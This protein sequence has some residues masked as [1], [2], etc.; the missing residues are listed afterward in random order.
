MKLKTISGHYGQSYNL[1]HNNRIFIPNNVDIN[2]V[3][4][5][6]YCI[7][8]GQAAEID[9]EQP[10]DLREFWTR[11]RELADIYWSDRS[12]QQTLAYEKYREQQKYMR[13]YYRAFY[14][15]PWNPISAMIVLLMLPLLIP[16]GLYLHRQQALARDELEA[17]QQDQMI[18]DLAFK[19]S[20]VSLRRALYEQDLSAGTRY[21]RTMDSVVR[22]MSQY[23]NDYL[24]WAAESDITKVQ[25]YRYATLEEIYKKLYEPSF[26]EFQQ[27][28]RPCR[29]YS[30]TYL[31]QIREQKAQ[32]NQKKQQT[33]NAKSRTTSEAIEI[34]FTIGDMDN[35]GYVN[36]AKDA[37][38]SE[39]LLKDYCDYL[40]KQH[41]IC[42][43]TTKELNNPDWQP[44]F[45]NGLIILNL[46]VHADEAT[47]GIHLTCIPYSRD[48]KRGPSVQASMGKAF[49]GMGYPST[50]KDVLDENGEKIP[51][52]NRQGDITYN[53][54]GSIRYK[55]EPDGQGIIDWIEDQ[56]RWIQKE[57]ANRYD[58]EREYKGRHPRGNL[59]TPDYQAARAKERQVACEQL[60]IASMENY[61]RHVYDLSVRLDDHAG[62]FLGQSENQNLILKCLE[63]CSDEEYGQVVERAYQYLDQLAVREQEHARRALVAQIQQADERRQK[64]TTENRF[65]SYTNEK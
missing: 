29:R 22:E 38:M 25:E 9:P 8:A 31:E 46:T 65:Q 41:N 7:A 23:A 13:R 54:D 35:T 45:K 56:K 15:I 20:R 19:A 10:R 60:L 11:Y 1:T 16:C 5:N 12:I 47:P 42:F 30:G 44:P 6:Y 33:K 55:Q 43:I 26:Q 21:L 32:E 3:A 63:L 2:R 36:A 39:I 50:W 17:M 52:K 34:V 62:T 28:Q 24:N 57:M 18:A 51:K 48:C 59:S 61:D 27:R 53:K 64:K 40:R 49:A 14:D 37:Q 58:W 4:G